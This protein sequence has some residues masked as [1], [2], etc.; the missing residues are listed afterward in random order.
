MTVCSWTLTL[1]DSNREPTSITFDLVVGDS[2]L[3]IGMDIRA[4]CNTFN[5]NNQNFISMKRPSDKEE[6]ILY[7]YLV[8]SDSRPRLD[9]APHPRSCVGTLPGNPRT[10]VK[11]TPLAL[12]KRVHRYTHASKADMKALCRDARILNPE[13]KKAIEAVC[14]ACEI[15]AKNGHPKA[16]RKV[17]PTHVNEA[18]NEELQIYF[19]FEN[20]RQ[21][22][23][24]VMNRTGT[25][26]AYSEVAVVENRNMAT[27][28]KAIENVWIYRHG[29]P[30]AVSAD[31]EYNRRPLRTYLETHDVLF[32]PPPTRRHNKLGIVWSARMAL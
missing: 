9:V 21:A 25:G 31:D 30:K 27:I 12:C 24:A 29:A 15:Y 22:Q 18:F 8:P 4:H 6:R 28:I 1:Q 20:A 5:R 10:T 3:I 23:R 11:R 19:F 14:D 17:S 7:T 32:R 26:T 16:S 13:M 2:P